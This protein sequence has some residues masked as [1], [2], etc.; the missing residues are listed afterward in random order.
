MR[1]KNSDKARRKVSPTKDSNKR[2]KDAQITGKS[3]N[4]VTWHVGH[5]MKRAVQYLMARCYEGMGDTERSRI[6]LARSAR[7]IPRR[8][9]QSHGSTKA[10]STSKIKDQSKKKSKKKGVS[11]PQKKRKAITADEEEI[12]A[13]YVSDDSGT[14]ADDISDDDEGLGSHSVDA[15]DSAEGTS[16]LLDPGLALIAKKGDLVAKFGAFWA[17][18]RHYEFGIDMFR[19]ALAADEHRQDWWTLLATCLKRQGQTSEAVEAAER[20]HNLSSASGQ[21]W[22]T[23]V[24]V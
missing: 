15:T 16:N 3:S 18:R 13:D 10:N 7:R 2:L 24:S 1:E 4:E 20:A 19:T 14:S 17:N 9:L 8:K 12:P 22:R 5:L 21:G 6:M 11:T 23:R